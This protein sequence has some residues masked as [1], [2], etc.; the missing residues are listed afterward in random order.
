MTILFFPFQL[1]YMLFYFLA[2]LH[3]TE[4]PEHCCMKVAVASRVKSQ[5]FALNLVFAMFPVTRPY[6]D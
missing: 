4:A 2:L 3:W 6:L 5:H 1:F